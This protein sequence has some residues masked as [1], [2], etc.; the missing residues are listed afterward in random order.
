MPGKRKSSD[1]NGNDVSSKKGKA[2]LALGPSLLPKDWFESSKSKKFI[3]A[4]L[5][6]AGGVE[7]ALM[8]ASSIGAQA[9]ACFLANQRTWN[10]KPIDDA[11]VT[12]FK[13]IAE[14]LGY[15]GHLIMPHASYLLNLGSPDD[16]GLKKSRALFLD[17]LKR[18]DKLGIGVYNFHPGSTLNKISPK[19]CCEK[20]A[21]SINYAHANTNNVIA[22]IE[23]MSKQGG[24]VGGDFKEIKQ[25]IDL[26]K[27]KSRVGVCFDTCHAFQAGYDLRSDVAYKKTWEEFDQIVGLKYLKGIHLN[28]SKH[29]IN[30]HLDR[31]EL[32][33]K[34][35]L[36]LKVFKRIMNDP[37]LE[38]IPIVLETPGDLETWKY[39]IELL[40]SQ[41]G[42]D[43][44]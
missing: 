29:D 25:I 30:C 7:N 20:I 11:S 12:K 42:E 28:D 18:C 32:I 13:N 43:D 38:N 36:G 31:H 21:E 9:V 2:K 19:K 35:K 37:N 14:E 39:E 23:N 15:P 4:H 41:I 3:G 5:S 6:I 8:E 17:G 40:Y 24:C 1:S 34:G 26:V 22:V 44:E 33:G 27:D 10:V 16:E